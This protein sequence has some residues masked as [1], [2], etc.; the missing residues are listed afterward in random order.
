MLGVEAHTNRLKTSLHRNEDPV[1]PEKLKAT[2]PADYMN[3]LMKFFEDAE[4]HKL[5]H[6]RS[7]NLSTNLRQ[8]NSKHSETSIRTALN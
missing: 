3:D 5:R 2:Y 8:G 7:M 6:A 1:K 4:R